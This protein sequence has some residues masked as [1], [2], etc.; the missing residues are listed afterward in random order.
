MYNSI[1]LQKETNRIFATAGIPAHI[2]GFQY[3]R[4]AII[5]AIER[6]HFVN[7]MTKQ[8]YPK[9]A[10]H[11]ETSSSKVERAIR[12]AIEVAWTR[13]HTQTL[14]QLFGIPAFESNNRPTNGEFIALVADKLMIDMLE[15]EQAKNICTNCKRQCS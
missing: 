4:L 15:H 12:H 11:F 9:I 14:N 5:L 13:G 8:L 6:Q 1:F 10:E 2:K 7:N 3:L